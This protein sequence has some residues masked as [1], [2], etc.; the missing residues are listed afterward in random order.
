MPTPLIY[1]GTVYVLG[2]AGI[3][4]AYD[5]KTGRENLPAAPPAPGIRVQRLARGNRTER[6]IYRAKT[7]TFLWS[8]PANDLSC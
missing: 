2:N 3:F 5:L 6:S 8:A 1:R 4:D 7:A